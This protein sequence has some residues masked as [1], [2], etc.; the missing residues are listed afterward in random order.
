MFGIDG[1][2]IG[3]IITFVCLFAGILSGF[4]VAF[5]IGGAGI[6][7][8]GILNKKA[9]DLIQER[10]KFIKNNDIQYEILI[11]KEGNLVNSYSSLTSTKIKSSFFCSLALSILLQLLQK[12]H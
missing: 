9:R 10:L 6:V 3:L 1:V 5:G 12:P 8:F 4:P 2:I 11:D 7:S